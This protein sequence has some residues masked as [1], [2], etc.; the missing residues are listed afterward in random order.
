MN[1]W[2]VAATAFFC[3][4]CWVI[5]QA[6]AGSDSGLFVSVRCVPFGD[7]LGHVVLYGVLALLANLALAGRFLKTRWVQVGSLVVLTF[8]ICE[9]LTQHFNPN[10]TLDAFD[11]AADVLGVGIATWF[12]PV[13][14]TATGS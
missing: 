3:F 9:E 4:I 5:L 7:K 10:R 1:R 14:D 12:S 13:R 2:V 8:A 11:A 6:N